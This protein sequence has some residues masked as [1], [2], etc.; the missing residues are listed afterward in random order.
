MEQAGWGQPALGVSASTPRRAWYRQ[1]GA[2]VRPNVLLKSTCTPLTIF[3]ILLVYRYLLNHPLFPVTEMPLTVFDDL[4]GFWP[5]SLLPYVTL[6]VYVS[7]PPALLQTRRELVEYAGAI[8]GLCLIGFACF[9]LWPTVV[10][11]PGLDRG[12]HLGFDVLLGLDAAGNACPSLHVAT[13]L[14]SGVWLDTLLGEM[15]AGRV[16]RGVN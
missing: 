7:L 9:L 12:R 5:P 4:I 1:L 8:W 13:A 10:P 2:Q 11:H 3:I 15:G 16:A 14:F 6:W